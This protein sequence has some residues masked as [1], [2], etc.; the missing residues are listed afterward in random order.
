M[1]AKD[2]KYQATLNWT[3]NLGQGT[4]GYRDYTRDYS[5]EIEGKP[6]IHGSS[7]PAFLGDPK[8]HNPEDLFLA[9]VSGCHMLWYLHLCSAAGIIVTDYSD[10]ASGTMVEN[11]NGSGQ[12]SSVLLQPHVTIKD[13]SRTAEAE[14]LHHKVGDLCFIARSI[15]TPIRYQVTISIEPV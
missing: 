7:D 6:T 15:K 9:S 4:K 1:N 10:N 11:A 14:Q 13:A 5:I 2:H 12:F 3:G 8:R